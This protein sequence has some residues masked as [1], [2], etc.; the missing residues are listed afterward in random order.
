MTRDGD[1]NFL[2]WRGGWVLKMLYVC[3]CSCRTTNSWPSLSTFSPI[4]PPLALFCTFTKAGVAG[5]V[6]TST[7]LWPWNLNPGSEPPPPIRLIS[8]N[9][10]RMTSKWRHKHD[11][12][13][14]YGWFIWLTFRIPY[15]CIRIRIMFRFR[16]RIWVRV[17]D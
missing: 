13:S 2:F 7:Y 11:W 6:V 12:T 17:R 14:T 8:T 15:H 3:G 10:R 1:A 9:I 5:G 16:V 4:L